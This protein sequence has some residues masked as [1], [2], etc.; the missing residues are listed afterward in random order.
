MSAPKILTP[1]RYVLSMPIS[2]SFDQVRYE[3]Y[4][5][6]GTSIGTMVYKTDKYGWVAHWWEATP[7]SRAWHSMYL[8]KFP[9]PMI[10][11]DALDV[12]LRAEGYTLLETQDELDKYLILQ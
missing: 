5:I 8:T 12:F 1:Y 11:M 7:A 4:Q 9:T 3:R 10:A 6:D 2:H